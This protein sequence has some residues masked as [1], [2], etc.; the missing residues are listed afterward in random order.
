MTEALEYEYIEVKAAYEEEWSF[1]L[2]GCYLC[3]AAIRSRDTH[4]AWH[5]RQKQ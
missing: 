1:T 3:G 5:E 2:Y 4:N